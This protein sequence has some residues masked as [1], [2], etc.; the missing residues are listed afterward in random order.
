[1]GQTL[2][3][4]IRR[5]SPIGFRLIYL[6]LTLAHSKGQGH[7]HSQFDWKNNKKLSH[8]AFRRISAT[9]LPFLVYVV[10][11]RWAVVICDVHDCTLWLTVMTLLPQ[12]TDI[13]VIGHS[14]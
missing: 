4:P 9:T 12:V 7:Q 1:M 2:L 8:V 6:H 5:K 14:L 13:S 3:L 10:C 11:A